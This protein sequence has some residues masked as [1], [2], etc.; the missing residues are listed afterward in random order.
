MRYL[1]VLVGSLP[2]DTK[3]MLYDGVVGAASVI[4]GVG[5]FVRF[6]LFHE[7]DFLGSCLIGG[8]GPVQL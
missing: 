4:L 3:E 6:F 2:V 5:S 7:A 8:S 1:I